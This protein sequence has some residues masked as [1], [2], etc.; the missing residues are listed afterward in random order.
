MLKSK[1]IRAM[2]GKKLMARELE[3][4]KDL[5]KLQTQVAS[6]SPPENTGKIRAIKRELARIKTIKGGRK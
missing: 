1:E 5:M 6:G 3:L 2:D 4:H